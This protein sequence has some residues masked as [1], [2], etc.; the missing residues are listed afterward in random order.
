MDADP[1]FDMPS[2][3]WITNLCASIDHI[4]SHQA[5]FSCMTE[6][7]LF[8]MNWKATSD[9]IGITDRLNFI[10]IVFLGE[11]IET[12]I[13]FVEHIN[14]IHWGNFAT[15]LCEIDNIREEN[16]YRWKILLKSEKKF[17]KKVL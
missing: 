16:R 15:N 9:H 10:D 13:G 5:N 12:S 17:K 3:R 1:N 2:F 6:T 14:H 8:L 7:A 4:S 11:M